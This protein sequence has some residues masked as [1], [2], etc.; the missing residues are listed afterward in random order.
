MLAD[1]EILNDETVELLCEQA[2]VQARAGCDVIAPSDMMD[3]RVG[4]IRRALD[5][6]GHRQVLIMA[7]AAKYASSFYGPFR[8]AIGSAGALAGGDKRSYQMDPP[9]IPTRRCARSRSTL[10][11]GRRHG[12]GQ[13]GHALSRCPAGA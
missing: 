4:A 1:G 12:D 2:L 5:G 9:P 8:E 3:G 13:A 10:A 6:A 7:Y 11:E